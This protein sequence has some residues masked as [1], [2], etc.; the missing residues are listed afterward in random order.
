MP[1]LTARD[2]WAGTFEHALDTLDAP[3]GDMPLHLGAPPKPT[4][5]PTVEASRPLN[6]LQQDIAGVL[7][8]LTVGGGQPRQ[9]QQQQPQHPTVQGEISEWFQSRVNEHKTRT[10]AWL[11]K[12]SAML[13]VSVQASGQPRDGWLDITW[14]A[15][16]AVQAAAGTMTTISTMKLRA[17]SAH[18]NTPYCLDTNG[19]LPGSVVAATVCYPAADPAR[20]RDIDQQWIVNADSTIRPAHDAALCLTAP[21]TPPGH[22]TLQPCAAQGVV[23]QRW[24]Y[25]GPNAPGNNNEGFILFGDFANFLGIPQVQQ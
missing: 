2:A 11:E 3:R 1:P 19:T 22:A 4:L 13:Q 20:N 12:S 10:T 25:H 9:Q 7:D 15:A 21:R 14:S 17:D 18:H 5:P 16:P 8:R 6:D 23:E 24:S